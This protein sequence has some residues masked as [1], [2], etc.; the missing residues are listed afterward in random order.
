MA[1]VARSLVRAAPK[2][3]QPIGVAAE[4]PDDLRLEPGRPAGQEA[5]DAVSRRALEKVE[6]AVEGVGSG[7]HHGDGKTHERRVAALEERL[8][9]AQRGIGDVADEQELG[10]RIPGDTLHLTSCGA[11]DLVEAL[12]S[13]RD[14]ASEARDDPA[15]ENA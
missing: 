8:V 4:V 5:V 9:A 15:L 7:R 11:A 1:V 6:V 3:R 14:R 12:G 13:G 2:L 10:S